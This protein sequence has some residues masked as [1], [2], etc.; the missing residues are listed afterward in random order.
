MNLSHCLGSL[1]PVVEPLVHPPAECG[2]P[3]YSQAHKHNQ[4][5]ERGPMTSQPLLLRALCTA[6]F[7]SAF[8]LAGC[9]GS[10]SG[11]GPAMTAGP[12][13]AQVEA[14]L[15]KMEAYAKEL[16]ATGKAPGMAIAVVFDDEVVYLGGF[17]RR[18]EGKPETVDVDTVFQIASLSKP[19]A[20]TTVAA[21]VS[22]GKLTWNSRIADLDPG[23]ALFDARATR[24]LTV[25]DLFSHRSG[26]PGDAGN[27]LWSL[28]FDRDTILARLRLV[29]LA[30]DFRSAYAYSNFGLTEGAV[31]AA[32]AVGMS[33]EDAARHYL[34]EPLGMN[35]TDSS[36]AAFARQ[37]NRASLHVWNQNRWRPLVEQV[38][39]PEAPAGGV[40]TNVRD[41]AQWMRL[42]LGK[43][44][45]GAKRVMAADAL[46]ATHEPLMP[47]GINP[48]T[49]TSN[50]YGLGWIVED[51]RHG[52]LWEHAGAFS[53]G[54]RSVANLLPEARLGIVVLVNA[55]PTGAPEAVADTFFD[56]VF[57]GGASKD[58]Y[59]LWNPFF[60]AMVDNPAVA[61]PIE[62]YGTPPA[63][64]APARPLSAYL[65]VY[66]SDYA[67]EMIVEE[68]DGRLVAR[69][70]PHGAGAIEAAG[71]RS[72]PINGAGERV[73][74]LTH[75]DGD[76]FT[77]RPVL[78]RPELPTPI[79]F[80]MGADQRAARVS[81]DINTFGLGA[82]ERRAQ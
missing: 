46:A 18:E 54:A 21:M 28:G 38:A 63:G 11:S 2:A 65:G 74:P 62:T 36:Y 59:A 16:V 27:D 23:F 13:R 34:Y 80:E 42:E 52:L 20:A 82:F 44:M 1:L 35:S 64:A 49:G 29:P 41:L 37:S 72:V 81:V 30:G 3:W 43:G 22:D 70:G 77:S 48:F 50:A 7:A 68:A 47:S 12:T 78:E 57:D 24:E 32:K 9:G 75:F 39:D 69:L 55:F 6:A 56:Q 45:L 17:G 19:I 40:S 33:W 15:P 66:V 8:A 14:A 76:V 67:G 10:G 58:W 51:G 53:T 73:W 4:T 60:V 71:G 5:K 79:T 61:R 26:L 31:A 25:S